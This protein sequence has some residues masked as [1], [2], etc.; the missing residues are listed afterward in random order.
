MDIK[1]KQFKGYYFSAS[2]SDAEGSDDQGNQGTA[3]LKGT[4]SINRETVEG[5][6]REMTADAEESIPDKGSL[7]KVIN[8]DGRSIGQDFHVTNTLSQEQREKII[9]YLN[10]RKACDEGLPDHITY[11]EPLLNREDFARFVL[12]QC[13]F[14]DCVNHELLGRNL[15][16]D[17][18]LKYSQ[19]SICESIIENWALTGISICSNH[20]EDEKQNLPQTRL[21]RFEERFHKI[22]GNDWEFSTEERQQYLT[23]LPGHEHFFCDISIP[24]WQEKDQKSGEWND[25]VMFQVHEP[26]RDYCSMVSYIQNNVT[27]TDPKHGQY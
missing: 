26:K 3:S 20:T 5:G 6:E 2:S 15:S 1:S 22:S 7:P 21:N 18:L 13:R 10:G 12:P 9:K 24:I 25:M 16:M 19:S 23:K 4:K 14:T 27:T 11:H 17:D 8:D